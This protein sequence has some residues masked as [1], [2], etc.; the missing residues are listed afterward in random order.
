MRVMEFNNM[1]S[2]IE[3]VIA[4]LGVAFVPRSAILTYE[5]KGLLKS[6]PV[7]QPYSFTNTFLIRHKDCLMTNALTKFIELVAT[8]TDYWPVSKVAEGK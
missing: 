2:I 6:L 7:P 4:G 5:N 1:K 3:G 8:E